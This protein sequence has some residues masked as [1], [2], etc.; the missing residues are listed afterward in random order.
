MFVIVVVRPVQQMQ[1]GRCAVLAHSVSR[2]ADPDCGTGRRYAV[3]GSTSNGKL[4]TAFPLSLGFKELTKLPYGADVERLG[5][6][7]SHE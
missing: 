7:I 2:N 1:N 6:A 3:E 5:D 4:L